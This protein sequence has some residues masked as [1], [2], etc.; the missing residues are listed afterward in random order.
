MTN[1]WHLLLWPEQDGTLSP[2]VGWLTM[3]HTQRWHAYRGTV[4]SGHLYQGRFKSFVVEADEHLKTV[5][6]YVERNALRAGL[7][8]HAEAGAWGSLRQ[9]QSGAEEGW[10]ALTAG[11]LALPQDWTAWVN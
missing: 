6:R 1:H 3:T 5:C 8:K 10:P 11:P 2:F 7:V 4:G 9:R